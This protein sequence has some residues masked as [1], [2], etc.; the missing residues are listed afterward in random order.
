MTRKDFGSNDGRAGI[1][2]GSPER[3]DGRDANAVVD[4]A[5]RLGD[6]HRAIADRIEHVDLA[7]CGCLGDPARRGKRAGVAVRPRSK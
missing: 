4:D 3:P 2:R 1:S 5:D 7:A 6:G